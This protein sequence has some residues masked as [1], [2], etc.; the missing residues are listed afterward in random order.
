MAIR[1]GNREG[2]RN[3]AS[4]GRVPDLRRHGQ[5]AALPDT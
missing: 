4:F 1:Q 3:E 5:S 2:V